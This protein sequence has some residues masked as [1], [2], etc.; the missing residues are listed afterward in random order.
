[1]DTENREP[2][3]ID[4]GVGMIEEMPDRDMIQVL[5][6]LLVITLIV[7]LLGAIF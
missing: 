7:L 2:E 3:L 6:T 4:C 5:V 1:M